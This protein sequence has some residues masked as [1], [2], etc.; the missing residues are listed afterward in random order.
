MKEKVDEFMKILL[1]ISKKEADFIEDIL[2]W[3]NEDKAAFLLAKKLHE[4]TS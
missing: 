2:N 4:L 3:T 1:R